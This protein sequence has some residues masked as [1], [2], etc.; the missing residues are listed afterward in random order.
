MANGPFYS[1]LLCMTFFPQFCFLFVVFFPFSCV[2]NTK[3]TFVIVV[4]SLSMHTV[5]L[6]I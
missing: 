3:A 6:G 5:G 2:M 4:S 1:V